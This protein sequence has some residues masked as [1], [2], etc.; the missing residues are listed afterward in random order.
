M[1]RD[2]PFMLQEADWPALIVN[3]A[4]IIC[5][6]NSK[7]I[8]LFGPALGS[9]TVQ[10]ST[11]WSA[12]NSQSAEQF[13]IQW[14]YSPSSALSLKFRDHAGKT[15]VRVVCLCVFAGH[16]EKYFLFQLLPAT[17][18][19]NAGA[20]TEAAEINQAHKQK[21]ECALQLAR[22]ISLD[23]NNALTTIVA[24]TSLLLS[25]MELDHPWR[26]PMMEVEKS[27]ARA[28]ELANDLGAFSRQEKEPRGQAAGNL[29]LLLQRCVESSQSRCSGNGVPVR[30][31]MQVERKLFSAR[32]D[33]PKMQQAF[34]KIIDNAVESLENDGRVTIQTRNLELQEATQDRNVRL[35]PGAYVTVEISDNG[36]GI[37]PEILPRIFEPFFTTK[38]NGNHRGLG[39]AWVYGIITNHAG[40]V[41]VSSQPGRGTSVRVY[42]PAEK[43]IVKD[44][45]ASTTDLAGTETILM[46]DDEDL[47]LRMGQ[48]ILSSYGY[49]VLTAGSGKKALD[50]LAANGKPVHLVLTDLVMPGMSGRELVENIR[51]EK[52]AMRILCTSG[53]SSPAQHENGP[54]LQKPFTTQELLSK[55][56]EALTG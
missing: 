39:L 9:S 26:G 40:G 56:R 6:C 55:V 37:A 38:K 31:T 12:D 25:K 32:F 27:A 10:L 33:E 45:P 30:W 17:P 5:R 14:Q 13:L 24:H 47:L 1:N 49:T 53:Y 11:I 34:D 3:E 21:L 50:I 18:P 8:D 28:T 46:V 7:A 42:L 15:Y 22:T 43:K 52:P 4:G 35:V 29:N 41:A 19:A 44:N 16:Q 20:R 36:S 51:K 23:F 54:F 48:T 2:L